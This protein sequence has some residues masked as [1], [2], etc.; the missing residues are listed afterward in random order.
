M[1]GVYD[2]YLWGHLK[3]TVYSTN[4]HTLDE[5]KASIRGE[6]DSILEDEFNAYKCTFSKKMPEMS[7]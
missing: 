2:F 5:L 3:N 7:G 6:I 1:C 4:P